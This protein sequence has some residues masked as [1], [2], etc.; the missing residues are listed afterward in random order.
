M[1]AMGAPKT[2]GGDLEIK[3]LEEVYDRRIHVY[4]TSGGSGTGGATRDDPTRGI[5][6]SLQGKRLLRAP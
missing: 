4:S 1:R 3:A 5:A 6:P 2:W